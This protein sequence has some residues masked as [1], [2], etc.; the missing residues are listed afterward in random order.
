MTSMVTAPQIAARA[1]EVI[2][3]TASKWLRPAIGIRVGTVSSCPEELEV[4]GR[5]LR[6]VTVESALAAREALLETGTDPGP[7]MILLTRL[8]EAALGLDVLA[9]LTRGRLFPIEPWE[10]LKQHFQARRIDARLTRYPWMANALLEVRRGGVIPTVPTGVL[11]ERTAWDL[12]LDDRLG[13]RAARWDLVEL[14]RWSREPGRLESWHSL[15]PEIA[16]G[17]RQWLSTVGGGAVSAF[18]DCVE[19]GFGGDALPVAIAAEIVCA[20]Q[21]P[22]EV[23]EARVRLERWF[24]GRPMENS[25]A[26]GWIAAGREIAETTRRE[27][28]RRDLDRAFARSEEIL[29]ELRVET[30]LHLGS[31]TRGELEA[32]FEQFGRALIEGI[33]RW[34]AAPG[35]AEVLPR[36]EATYQALRQHMMSDSLPQYVARVDRAGMAVRIARWLGLQTRPGNETSLAGAVASYVAEGSYLDRART[37]LFGVE[38][39]PVLAEAYQAL[40]HRARTFCEERNARFGGL[41]ARETRAGEPIADVVPVESF[42]DELLGPIAQIDSVLLVVM[43]GMSFAVFRELEESIARHGWIQLLPPG[44]GRCP[45][46]LAGIPSVTEVS[47]ACLLSGRMATGAAG[48]ELTEFTLHPALNPE[49]RTEA[50]PD[51]FFKGQVSGGDLS[52]IS[53]EIESAIE[54]RRIRVVGVVMNA[55]DDHLAKGNQL[56]MDWSLEQI[57]GLSRLFESARRARRTVVV[58]SDHGHVLER[59]TERMVDPRTG[60]A[61]ESGADRYRPDDGWKYPGEEAIGGPRVLAPGGSMVGLWSE[62]RRYS[63][64][65][66]GYHGGISPQE[67]VIPLGVYRQAPIE[68]PWVEA[69]VSPPEWWMG[70]NFTRGED[71]PPAEIR[72]GGPAPLSESGQT[73]GLSSDPAPGESAPVRA[74]AGWTSAL[75]ESPLFQAQLR[76]Q[77]RTAIDPAEIETL[78]VALDERG[79]ALDRTAL[80]AKLGKPVFRVDGFVANVGRALN[81]D[82]YEILSIDESGTVRLDTATL[83]VQFQLGGS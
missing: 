40:M 28:A 83:R 34:E 26:Q 24:S 39:H 37:R 32:R 1:G 82:G 5:V 15:E 17:A 13:L 66:N 47:R 10:I 62:A 74:P 78:L 16:R 53:P 73:S 29:R 27:T 67:M 25:V 19:S 71:R 57:A 12:L 59:G 9:R 31:M 69:I 35:A 43:D 20:E 46:L 11:D 6:V 49:K 76:R 68:G 52:E 79:G 51:L 50:R 70:E 63:V 33:A 44:R 48:F 2:E 18:F 36:I 64:K 22:P 56:L 7:R 30:Y 60:S 4:G 65:K 75:L 77:S 14:L 58:T 3:S 21:A 72:K 61:L 42:I 41:L 8:D 23:R 55:V 45:S 54:S 80:A 38:P 81:L